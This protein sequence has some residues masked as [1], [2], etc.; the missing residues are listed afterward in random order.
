MRMQE[1][2]QPRDGLIFGWAEMLA[3]RRLAF[4]ERSRG[5]L[6][7]TTIVRKW[8]TSLLCPLVESF[9]RRMTIRVSGQILG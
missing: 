5:G 8:A 9:I 6:Q 1:K 3:H 7:D 4:R 2:S